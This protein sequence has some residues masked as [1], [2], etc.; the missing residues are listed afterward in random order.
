[1]VGLA[2]D[3]SVPAIFIGNKSDLKRLRAVS[4]DEGKVVFASVYSCLLSPSQVITDS[5]VSAYIYCRQRF[6]PLQT[7]FREVSL[8]K[9]P[10]PRTKAL[11]LNCHPTFAVL[12]VDLD[13]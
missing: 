6:L 8:F 11:E 4:T 10:F 1:M 3:T 5:Y 13:K 12:G 9:S 2:L 7:I